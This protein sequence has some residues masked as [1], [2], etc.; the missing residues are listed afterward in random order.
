MTY[1]LSFYVPVMAI[2]SFYFV[3][4]TVAWVSNFFE[5]TELPWTT[6]R[7]SEF[8][9]QYCVGTFQNAKDVLKPDSDAT[10]ISSAEQG[11]IYC[12]FDQYY[13]YYVTNSMTSLLSHNVAHSTRP[14]YRTKTN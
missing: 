3:V 5:T 9:D 13:R 4:S 8:P 14:S 2:C 10:P 6:C 1:V 7:K 11:F 12:K